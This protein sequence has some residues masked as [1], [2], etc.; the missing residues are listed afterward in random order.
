MA[1]NGNFEFS[2]TAEESYEADAIRLQDSS[3][4]WE[5]DQANVTALDMTIQFPDGGIY[6]YDIAGG[7]L[8]YS[9]G[10]S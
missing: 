7:Y 9:F 8:L 10:K 3:T 5:S 6:T 2:F 1:F 4:D